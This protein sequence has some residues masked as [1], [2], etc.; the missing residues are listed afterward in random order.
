MKPNMKINIKKL[1]Q[2]IRV[3]FIFA[4]RKHKNLYLL[5]C[6]AIPALIM[7]FMHACVG[8]WPFGKMTVLT[9][10]LNA[11]YVFFFEALRD[12]VYGNGSLLYTFTRSL[13]GEFL[14][15]YAYYLASPLS[16]IVALFPKENMTEALFFMF[17][18]KTGL[19]GLTFGIFLKIKDKLK[20]LHAILFST[21]YALAGYGTVMQHNTMWIDNMILLPLVVLGLWQLIVH[22]RYLLYTLSLALC[23]FSNFYIGYMTCIFVLFFTFAFYFSMTKRERNPKGQKLHFARA[24]FRVG[25]FSVIAILMASIIL[26]PAYYALSFGKNDFTV[27]NYSATVRAELLDFFKQMLVCSY[28]TVRPDGMPNIY[29]G[30]LTL[31]LLPL[32]FG[33]RRIR[34]R[35]KAAFGA[36]SFVLLIS[37]ATNTFDMIWHGFQRPNWLEYRYSFMLS[38]LFVYMACRVYKHLRFISK[39]AIVICSAVYVLLIALLHYDSPL[40]PI[41]KESENSF[42]IFTLVGSLLFLGVYAYMLVRILSHKSKKATLVLKRTLAAIVCLELCLNGVYNLYYLWFD[43]GMSDRASYKDYISKWQPIVDEIQIKDTDFYRMEKLPYRRMNDPGALG[44]RGLTASTSTLHADAIAFLEYMGISADSH[45]SEYCG[46]SP[47]TDSILGIKYLL[48][49]DDQRRLSELYSLYT[50]DTENGTT[51][52]LNPYA[53]P[54]A[55]CVSSDINGISFLKNTSEEEDGKKHLN[56][57]YS[58]FDRMN[59]LVS[60]MMGAEDTLQIYIPLSDYTESKENITA[61]NSGSSRYYYVQNYSEGESGSF[62]FK[63]A[64]YEGKELYAFFPDARMMD[65]LS[66]RIDDRYELSWFH[67]SG[68]GTLHL[69]QVDDGDVVNVKVT[70]NSDERFYMRRVSPK[71]NDLYGVLSYFYALDDALFVDTF[72]DLKAGGLV[73]SE[74]TED[75]FKGTITATSDRQ[76][77]LTTIPFDEGW[78]VTV[79]GKPVEVYET[80]DALLAF[81]V[82]EG[83]HSIEMVYRPEIYKTAV[84][85][86]AAGTLS[87]GAIIAA[88]FVYKYFKNKKANSLLESENN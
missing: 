46:S 67:N 4:H 24:I 88:E 63:V 8:V 48:E 73:I 36:I 7:T 52:Y 2:Q 74:Y 50:S 66:V 60:T 37:F 41:F 53:L 32:Y 76:T 59:I 71:D 75:S 38:F 49:Y 45:W 33:C 39:K 3:R 72:N 68:Y 5:W 82:S 30:M 40:T 61:T 12:W 84:L 64:G 43:V 55:F 62:T 23:L 57:I 15:I 1:C 11:Q 51:A 26:L 69:G 16:F 17:V 6:F 31:L 28:D 47:V 44:F 79:D 10:D 29:S 21:I 22:R 86:C 81:D 78:K 58:V 14:G 65:G 13:G 77:V 54:I 87:L 42:R 56:N 9:L 27:P 34:G 20:G 18:V 83:Q 35:E 80:L 25:V 70:M 85:L 19:C